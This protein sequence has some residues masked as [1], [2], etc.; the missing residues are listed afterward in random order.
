MDRN[1]EILDDGACPRPESAE[2][3]LDP[4][5]RLLELEPVC[6]FDIGR[7]VESEAA[8]EWVRE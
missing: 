4:W 5:T 8:G 2:P 6:E 7:V 3:E 1:E